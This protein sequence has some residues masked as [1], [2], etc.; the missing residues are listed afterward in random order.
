MHAALGCRMLEFHGWRLPLSYSGVLSEHERCR[1]AA[2][3]FDTGHMG[4]FRIIGKGAAAWFGGIGTQ[5]AA[6]LRLGRCRYGF[7]LNDAGGVLDDTVLVRL[8]E[9]E[10]ILIVNAG[11]AATDFAWINARL[12]G[13]VRLENLSEAG[14][15]KID[16]QGPLAFEIL[17][18]LVDSDLRA[19]AYFSAFRT[20][21]RGGDCI[22]TRTGYTG[23]LGYEILAPGAAVRDLFQ[24]LL[25]DSRVAP[26]GLGA[27]DSLRL[28]MGYPLHGH[29]LST[30]HNPIEAGL[31]VFATDSHSYI[32]AAALARA[33]A[34][35]TRRKLV[36][37]MLDSRR[38]P[39]PGDA[40]RAGG[41]KAGEVTSGAFLPSLAC[42][43]GLAYVAPSF[44]AAGT[45]LHIVSERGEW[46]AHITE[47]PLYRHG[48]C[49]KKLDL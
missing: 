33:R 2:A 38:K 34:G 30:A 17:A 7:L 31:G 48:T 3:L 12:E 13:T 9:E 47:K 32:G 18:P 45:E 22:V 1:T 39:A 28:E 21:L 6:Q 11:T 14:W 43:G 42:G 46:I 5:N 8:D 44:A 20:R 37:L 23:E 19:L 10:F 35:G 29:E 15:S 25:A 49:R 16:L 41:E 27:R 36:A 4:L 26:A 40:L 24:Q